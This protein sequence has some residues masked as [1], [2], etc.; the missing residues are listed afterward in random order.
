[1]VPATDGYW[2]LMMDH[3]L[4]VRWWNE[5]CNG[6]IKE[7]LKMRLIVKGLSLNSIA[8]IN[9]CCDSD[10][11]KLA[12]L[13]LGHVSLD[14]AVDRIAKRVIGLYLI[15]GGYV[16]ARSQPNYH[17]YDHVP[18]IDSVQAR[19]RQPTSHARCLHSGHDIAAR[20]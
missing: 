3:L 16:A 9:G 6:G 14:V 2:L 15:A 7:V 11:P 5:T 8:V 10:D 13:R 18:P 17:L 12:L 20:H 4:S 1:M 19:R